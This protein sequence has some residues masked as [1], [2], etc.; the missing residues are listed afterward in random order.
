[1]SQPMAFSVS[2]E[3]WGLGLSSLD[4]LIFECSKKVVVNLPKGRYSPLR[5]A[6]LEEL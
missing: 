6:G 5:I 1:M 3:D 4:G 2:D